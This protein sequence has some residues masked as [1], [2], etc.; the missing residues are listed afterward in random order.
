MF[1]NSL[2]FVRPARPL[3]DSGLNQ[4][5]LLSMELTVG[6]SQIPFFRLR[7]FP[8]FPVSLK[9][10]MLS[11]CC[12]LSVAFFTTS[13][14]DLLGLVLE[15]GHG[16]SGKRVWK[17]AAEDSGKVTKAL[18]LDSDGQCL[19]KDFCIYVYVGMRFQFSFLM[20][21]WLCY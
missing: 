6:V 2:R 1:A 19:V 5:F 17:A 7:K 4:R 13:I 3:F 10:F 12:I 9:A 15:E 14:R 18:L 20:S 11:G 21:L 16:Q 8:P